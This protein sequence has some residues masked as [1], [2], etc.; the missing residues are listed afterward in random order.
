MTL[1]IS[2]N[3]PKNIQKIKK[4]LRCLII[5]TGMPKC[6]VKKFEIWIIFAQNVFF[7]INSM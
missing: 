5:A 2:K 1:S 6:Y 4:K 3:V 7:K